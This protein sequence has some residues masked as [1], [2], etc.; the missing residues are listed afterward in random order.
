MTLPKYRKRQL[1]I[2]IQQTESELSDYADLLDDNSVPGHYTISAY[3][4]IAQAKLKALKHRLDKHN[5]K[6]A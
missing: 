5:R 3:Q 1:V 2:A 4:A 6:Y